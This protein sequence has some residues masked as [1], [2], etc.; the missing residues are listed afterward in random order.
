MNRRGIDKVSET[1]TTQP[2]MERLIEIMADVRSR[3]I[4]M[5]RHLDAQ[6]RKLDDNKGATNMVGSIATRA[7]EISEQNK[8]TL[9]QILQQLD[10]VN[11]LAKSSFDMAA[12]LRSS[13]P[14]EP[15]EYPMRIVGTGE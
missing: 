10:G 9:D 13:R 11:E 14:P 3:V 5:E 4:S 7:L 2:V 6:D 1:E 8:V 12:E 15:E